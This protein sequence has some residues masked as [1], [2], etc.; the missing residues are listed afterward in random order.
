M[1]SI[2]LKNLRKQKGWKQ[3]YVARKIY[4][5]RSTYTQYELNYR[6]RPLNEDLLV[7]IAELY[8]IPVHELKKTA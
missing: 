1:I 6:K 5:C 7:R 2:T 8:E 3:E 4:V